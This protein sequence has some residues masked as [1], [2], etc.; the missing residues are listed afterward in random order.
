M[1]VCCGP[2]SLAG[3]SAEDVTTPADTRL[4]LHRRVDAVLTE[5]VDRMM[6]EVGSRGLVTFVL[7]A[8][9]TPCFSLAFLCRT[10]KEVGDATVMHL[11]RDFGFEERIYRGPPS[12]LRLY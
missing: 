1:R 12:L 9:Y 11:N 7:V 2:F 5:A 8:S 6:P 3:E 4:P 10:C